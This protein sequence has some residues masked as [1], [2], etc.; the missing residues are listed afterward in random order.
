MDSTVPIGQNN[1][2]P[3]VLS[4][5]VPSLIYHNILILRTTHLRR[6]HAEPSPN[7]RRTIAEGTK[8]RCRVND[9]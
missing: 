6:T 5:F 4:S 7:Q 9:F 8:L 2:H 3:I 1:C